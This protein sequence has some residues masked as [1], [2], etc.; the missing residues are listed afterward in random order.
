[1]PL[2]LQVGGNYNVGI[3]FVILIAFLIPLGVVI[4][5]ALLEQK[6]Y[7]PIGQYVEE[8]SEG[9][10]VLAALLLVAVF[11]LLGHFFLHPIVA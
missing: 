4:F 2:A 11:A 3:F 8:W 9:H 10:P 7:P 5:D 1:M 6:W